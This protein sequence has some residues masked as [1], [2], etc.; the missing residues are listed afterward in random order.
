MVTTKNITA[1]G[2]IVSFNSLSPLLFV[3]LLCRSGTHMES[4]QI[5]SFFDGMVTSTHLIYREA[6]KVAPETQLRSRR[7]FFFHL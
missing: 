3:E 6:D 1:G 2:Q 5:R 4:F 7:A